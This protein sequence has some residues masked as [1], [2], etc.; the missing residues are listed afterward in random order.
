MPRKPSRQLFGKRTQI[1][2]QCTQRVKAKDGIGA[3]DRA[4]KH[5]GDA[6][7]NILAGL[8]RKVAVQFW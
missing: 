1:Y 6:A 2:R 4:D 7:S 5:P 3:L 8:P